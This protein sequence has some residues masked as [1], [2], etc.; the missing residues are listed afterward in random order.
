MRNVAVITGGSSGIGLATARIFAEHGYTVYE[1]SRKGHGEGEIRHITADVSDFSSVEA[2]LRQVYEAEGRLDVL[3]NNAGFGISGAVECTD[4]ADIRKLFDVNVFG[5]V[6]CIQCA[7]PYMRET[8][9]GH[10]V[11]LSSVAAPLSIPFQ[12]FYSCTKAAVS[13]LTLALANELRPFHISVCA[14]MPGDIRT[15]FTEARKK[16]AAGGAFYGTA[17]ERS[18]LLMERDEKNGM[19]PE[20][21]ARRVFVAAGKK[22]P[23]PL[24]AVGAKYKLFVVTAR[25]LPVRFT[26]WVVGILYASTK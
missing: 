18:V 22:H 10:I 4:P 23:K 16:C 9:G 14:V 19:P 8:G 13:D 7:V 15:G 25:L 12:A 6:Y 24:Y 26:N 21:V 20:A 1:L 11:N 5:M 17:I 3:V 2:A